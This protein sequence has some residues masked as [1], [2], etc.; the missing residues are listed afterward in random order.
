MNNPWKIRSNWTEQDEAE[1]DAKRKL[2]AR[3][4]EEWDATHPHVDDD[5]DEQ[6]DE[7]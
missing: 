3:R 4:Q 7:E 5:E 1:L 6:D 2:A